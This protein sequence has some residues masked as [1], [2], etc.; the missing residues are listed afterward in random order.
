MSEYGDFYDELT[1]I[2]R[3][4]AEKLTVEINAL[5]QVDIWAEQTEVGPDGFPVF[6]VPSSG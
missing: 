1:Q 3:S 4:A 2:L 5:Y 6:V